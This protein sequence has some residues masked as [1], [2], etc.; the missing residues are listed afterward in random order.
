M[1][2]YTELARR[3]R[4]QE[5]QVGGSTSTTN[6]LNVNIHSIHTGGDSEKDKPSS[7][8]PEDTL[9]GSLPVDLAHSSTSGNE[10]D[11]LEAC[12]HSTPL[13]GDAVNAVN[14][15]IHELHPDRCA[16]CSGYARWLIAGGEKRMR[17]AHN[18]P[19]GSRRLYWQLIEG[20][21]V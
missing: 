14:R 21:K 16:V 19:E 13:R 1:V 5:P 20:G 18:S 10:N 12:E 2:R 7:A 4:E 6:I 3:L 9:E 8:R 17:E 15:C 11:A